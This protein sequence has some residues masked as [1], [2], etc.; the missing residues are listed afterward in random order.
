M[1][2]RK[3]VVARR[4]KAAARRWTGPAAAGRL[5]VGLPLPLIVVVA[6]LAVAAAH[7]IVGR[8]GR[9]RLAL[10]LPSPAAFMMRK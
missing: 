8:G 10:A 3:A 6:L 4:G 5:D 7:F 9:T 1:A 2:V